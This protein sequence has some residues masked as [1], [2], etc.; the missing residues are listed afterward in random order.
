MKKIPRKYY[1]EL[2]IFLSH[3]HTGQWSRGYRLMSRMIDF[4]GAR[5]TSNME[6]EVE[7]SEIYQYLVNNYANKV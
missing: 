6:R 4:Y 3:Y 2:I 7:E 5:W 1:L